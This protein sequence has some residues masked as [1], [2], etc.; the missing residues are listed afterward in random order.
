[1]QRWAMSTGSQN[2]MGQPPSM[3]SIPN[4]SHSSTASRE[5]L[6]SPN[7]R[8]IHT[9]VTPFSPHSLTTAAAFP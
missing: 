7:E 2:I 5:T 9:R 1:M 6:P 8:W 3:H 4:R